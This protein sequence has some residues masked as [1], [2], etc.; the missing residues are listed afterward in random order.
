MIVRDLAPLDAFEAARRLADLPGLVFL[1]SS[2]RPEALGEHARLG[3][4]SFV[5]ADPWTTFGVRNGRAFRDGVELPGAPLDELRALL[6]FEDLADAIADPP[7]FAGGAIGYIGYDFGRRLE[8]LPEPAESEPVAEAIFGVYDVVLAFDHTENRARLISSGRPETTPEARRRRAQAR[9]DVFL[10]RLERSAEHRTGSVT[11]LDFRP[12]IPRETHEARVAAAIEHVLA[13]DVFQVNLAQRF[14]APLPEGFDA[15]AFHGRLRTANPAPFSAYLDFDELRVASSSPERFLELRGG[16]I[17]ARP[18]K[19]TARRSDDPTEDAL[20]AAR[21]VASEKDRA[22]NVMI[23]DL[24]RND[25]SKVCDDASIEVPVLCGIESYAGLHHLV[26]VVTG[27]LAEGRDAIDALA[28]AFP[29]GS[30]TGAPKIRA[31]EIITALEG[32]GRGVYCGSIG[33]IGHDG[34]M[35]LDIAIRTVIFR[36]GEATFSVGGGITALSE[37]SAE[38][39]ETL[40]KAARILVAASSETTATG[41]LPEAGRREAAA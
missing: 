27:R 7:P 10:M 17:E 40:T 23:V 26:S 6:A 28:A 34:A 4:W 1:D 8:R 29:G 36:A 9:M 31:Q 11:R 20:A 19:G 41:T 16:R 32:H 2:M 33:W 18:I 37:P 22:E 35:D 25:L 15:L 39:E 3:R 30:I 24:M 21:L 5:A 38:Y 12:T 13:G 14:A